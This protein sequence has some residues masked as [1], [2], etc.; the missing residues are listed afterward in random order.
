MAAQLNKIWP[1]V[2]LAKCQSYVAEISNIRDMVLYALWC[3]GELSYYKL[4]LITGVDSDS[5]NDELERLIKND[6]IKVIRLGDV[7]E[8]FSNSYS[9]NSFR[10]NRPL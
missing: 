7:E 3:S 6:D 10:L 8:F 2:N 1:N 9:S 4:L 5:L